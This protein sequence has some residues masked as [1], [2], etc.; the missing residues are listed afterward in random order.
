MTAPCPDF[1][2]LLELDLGGGV[3]DAHAA[4]LRTRFDA[5]L[6]E[7]GLSCEG[8]MGGVLGDASW[9]LVVRGEASQAT[10]ADRAEVE[11]WARSQPEVVGLRIGELMDLREE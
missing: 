3:T 6:R 4:E 2:F 8:S 9:L 11:R 1:G 5:L 10:D 7:R